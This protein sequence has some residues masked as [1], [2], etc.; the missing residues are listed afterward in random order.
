MKL[1]TNKLVSVAF[2]NY[3]GIN[4]LK[5]TIPH[6]LRLKDGVCKEIIIVDNNSN[7]RSCDYIR[8]LLEKKIP[9]KL[10]KNIKLIS[11][12]KNLASGGMNSVLGNFKGDYLFISDNDIALD[13]NCFPNLIK[14]IESDES[15]AAVAPTYVNYFNKNIIESTGNWISLSFYNGKIENKGKNADLILKSLKISKVP[16]C[17]VLLLD[18]KCVS[19]INYIFDPDFFL[20]GED[21]D[22]CLRIWLSGKKVMY[23]P[24]AIAYHMESKTTEKNFHSSMLV[25]LRERNLITTF[26]KILGWKSIFLLSPYVFGMRF[27]AMIKDLSKLRFSNIPARLRAILWNLLNFKRTLK[28]RRNIQ[29]NRKISDKELFKLFTEKFLFR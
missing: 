11:N 28:K 27:V 14:V 4:I 23:E 9:N 8:S 13:E 15:I 18:S 26:F 7:D 29:K 17:G 25:Y 2:L 16:F 20:Y 1:I 21:V 3:N 24:N 10:I 22:L 19:S 6:I 5:K 12:K